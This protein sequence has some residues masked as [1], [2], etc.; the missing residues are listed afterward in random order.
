MVLD[1]KAELLRGGFISL[2]DIERNP[3]SFV[4]Q[5]AGILREYGEVVPKVSNRNW[6]EIQAECARCK[7][8]INEPI[9]RPENEATKMSYVGR[10]D[11]R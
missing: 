6:S 1:K 8:G 7:A 4:K 5:L 9:R 2:D 10:N 3:N 11:L